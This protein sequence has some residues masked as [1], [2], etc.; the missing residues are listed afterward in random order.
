VRLAR[1]IALALAS[2]AGIAGGT[3]LMVKHLND[4]P[5]VNPLGYVGFLL[6][7]AACFGLVW[8]LDRGPW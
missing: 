2:T 1:R 4:K 6:A 3:Y 5:H 7:L 8:A